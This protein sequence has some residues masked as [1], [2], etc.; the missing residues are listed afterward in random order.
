MKKLFLAITALWFLSACQ[1][2]KPK[3]DTSKY[4]QLDT[5]KVNVLKVGEQFI[6]FNYRTD[7][8]QFDNSAYIDIDTN[9]VKY[10]DTFSEGTPRDCDGCT[11]TNIE[12]YEPVAKGNT[13]IKVFS[14]PFS[15]VPFSKK[16]FH[17]IASKI[18]DS[19]AWQAPPAIQKKDS[20]RREAYKKQKYKQIFDSLNTKYF[21][22]PS[23]IL[24]LKIQ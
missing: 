14:R 18:S 5:G 15:D 20:I 4:K 8:L 13:E 10:V 11:A 7:G 3:F 19:L 9:F 1:D 24:R 21:S 17:E 22:K 12:I 16:E 6:L 2:N 23:V